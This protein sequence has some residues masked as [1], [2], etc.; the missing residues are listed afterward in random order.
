MAI[1]KVDYL[2]AQMVKRLPAMWETQ[3]WSL[4]QEDPLENEM[5][6]HSSTIAWKILWTDEPRKL[7]SMGSVAKSQTQLSD[8]TFTFK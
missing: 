4:G 7:W 8:F 5:A 3:V 6:T 1:H 2:V